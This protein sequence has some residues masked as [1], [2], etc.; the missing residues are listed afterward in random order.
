MQKNENAFLVAGLGNPGSAYAETRH[1]LGAVVV[2]ALAK[3]LSVVLHQSKKLKGDVA[4]AAVGGAMVHLLC[5]KTFMNLSGK[6]VKRALLHYGVDIHNLLVVVDDIDLAFGKQ[7]LRPAGSSGGH[8]GLKDVGNKLQ[9]LEFPRLR[10]GVGRPKDPVVQVAQYVLDAFSIEELKRIEQEV[11]PEAISRIK[12]W[13][14]KDGDR[15]AG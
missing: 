15:L 5:P 14:S 7:R 13:V 6:S 8:N 1:N 12:Q 9:T 10:I 11:I 2:R 3:N 4:V